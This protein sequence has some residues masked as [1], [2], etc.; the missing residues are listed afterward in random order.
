MVVR[1]CMGASVWGW[2]R[3]ALACSRDRVRGEVT[4]WLGASGRGL[5][6]GAG[7]EVSLVHVRG[8]PDS[9]CMVG[10]CWQGRHAGLC[11]PDMVVGVLRAVGVGVP[12]VVRWS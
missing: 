11:W 1:V 6:C 7:E 10:W 12:S 2:Y 4:G 8:V 3:L 5:A 9:R